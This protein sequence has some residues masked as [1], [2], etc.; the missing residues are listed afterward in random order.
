MIDSVESLPSAQIK[1]ILPCHCLGV[2]SIVRQEKVILG[3]NSVSDREMTL[4][5]ISV[6]PQMREGTSVIT[7]VSFTVGSTG[8]PGTPQGS[9]EGVKKAMSWSGPLLLSWDELLGWRELMETWQHFREIA[10]PW[11]ISSAKGSRPE[12][13][14]W[15]LLRGSERGRVRLRQSGVEGQRR[16]H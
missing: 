10:L 2:L 1:Q 3:P 5:E 14:A 12:G 15:M 16:D 8:A 6:S 11:S 9:P 7:S 13:T 4:L